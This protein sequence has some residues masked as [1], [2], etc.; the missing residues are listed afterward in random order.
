MKSL[1]IFLALLLTTTL[2]A[3]TDT[4]MSLPYEQIPPYPQSYESGSILSRLIDG[5]GYR[6]YWATEGL[7]AADTAFK[8]SEDGKSILE[9]A[10]HIHG[11]AKTTL[12]VCEGKPIV[13]SEEKQQH[14]LEELRAETLRNLAQASQLCLG[15]T[16]AELAQL[17]LIFKRGD[18]EVEMPFWH[19]INGQ[20]ADAIYHTGQIV[21]FRRTAGNPV[22][23]KVNVFMGRNR[24]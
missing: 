13:R 21:S 11:L 23:S 14:S 18:K 1:F 15:K 3:Q 5:L 6:Y 20:I 22:N 24:E 9:T 12:T 19:L 10:I 4:T 2:H 16:E 7:S 17:A 8:P